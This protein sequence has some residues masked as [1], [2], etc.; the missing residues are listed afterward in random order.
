MEDC[1][2]KSWRMSRRGF[3]QRGKTHSGLSQAQ[4]ADI[5]GVSKRTVQ[6]W[7]IC[8]RNIPEY[9]STFIKKV[10]DNE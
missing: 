6:A 7:E 8:A 4:A 5:L 3:R 1:I 10:M 2:I 9:I